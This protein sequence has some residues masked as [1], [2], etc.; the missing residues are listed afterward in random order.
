MAEDTSGHSG[1]A[2][3]GTRSP[4]PWCEWSIC[5][6]RTAAGA[7]AVHALPAGEPTGQLDAGASSTRL[8]WTRRRP[9]SE[10]G[11]GSRCQKYV[12]TITGHPVRP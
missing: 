8:T 10:A 6:A 1:T 7:S 12:K 4:C 9:V 11:V 5:T 2:V 3:A